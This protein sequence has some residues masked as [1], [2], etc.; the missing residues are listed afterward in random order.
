MYYHLHVTVHKTDPQR[1]QGISP[2]SPADGV[3]EPG[4]RPEILIPNSVHFPLR[5][6]SICCFLP[7]ND[8][9]TQEAKPPG[10]NISLHQD[11]GQNEN[12]I[13]GLSHHHSVLP[14]FVWPLFS[15]T[16]T[17]ILTLSLEWGGK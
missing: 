14:L 17:P 16:S 9:D 1:G 8:P 5:F 7:D 6:L 4:L 12:L 10:G 2:S 3:S 13:W 15:G 11:F